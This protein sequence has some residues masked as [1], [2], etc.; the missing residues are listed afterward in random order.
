M[1]GMSVPLLTPRRAG[2]L[3][4]DLEPRDTRSGG[5]RSAPCGD[6]EDT[7]SA[8]RRTLQ[9]NSRLTGI[10]AN[11]KRRRHVRFIAEGS[12]FRAAK[13]EPRGDLPRPTGGELRLDPAIG[14]RDLTRPA[15]LYL[16]CR[17]SALAADAYPEWLREQARRS[18]S[19]QAREPRCYFL[20]DNRER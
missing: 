14:P 12:F 1:S 7:L 9:P 17:L 6:A 3:E 8:Q 19:N 18:H 10:A 4:S 11:P 15:T 2:R 13:R 5:A 20:P 16:R